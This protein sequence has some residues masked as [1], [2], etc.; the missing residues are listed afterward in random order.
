[1]GPTELQR[2]ANAFRD[3]NLAGGL[4]LP[5]AWDAASARVLELAGFPA[6]ATASAAIAF[7]RGF[8]DGERIGRDRMLAEVALIARR[9]AVP[10]S[11]DIEAGYGPTTADIEATV[12]G[13]IAAGAVGINLEDG[14]PDGDAEPLFPL[15]DASNRVGAARA[16]ADRHGLALTINARTDV[17]LLGL[18]GSDAERLAIAVERG[19]AFLAAG[20]DVIF[21]PGLLDPTVV[22][23]V[24]DGIGGPVSLLAGP[25]AP[26]AA[27]LF[28]AGACRISVGPHLMLSTLGHLRTVADGVRDHGRFD[29][30][31][32]G[33]FPFSDANAMFEGASGT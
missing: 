18:G 8:A 30:F 25:G 24:V 19:R 1:M 4:L 22:R 21:V 26:P 14:Q 17:F 27:E 7:A 3:L 15:A 6:I 33:H 11:A 12:E 2:Q 10:V 29:A 9:V 16:V 5:N 23:Q 13:V 31:S 20:A 32:S 28:A